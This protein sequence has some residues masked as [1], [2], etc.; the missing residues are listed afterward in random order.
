MKLDVKKEVDNILI[1]FRTSTGIKDLN[2][3]NESEFCGLM[4]NLGVSQFSPF[5]YNKTFYSSSEFNSIVLEIL[6]R[7]KN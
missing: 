3:I 6:K 1:N 7:L 4:F 5:A 2:L